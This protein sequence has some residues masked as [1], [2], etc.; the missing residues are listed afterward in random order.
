MKKIILIIFALIFALAAVGCSGTGVTFSGAYWNADPMNRGVADIYEEC[1]YTV[2]AVTE[3]EF[4]QASDLTARFEVGEGSYYLT[5]LKTENGKYVYET[6]LLLNG[7]YISADGSE[8]EVD[9]DYINTKTVFSGIDDN[10]KPVKSERSLKTLTF[11]GDEMKTLGYDA[12]V[13]YGDEAKVTVTPHEGSEDYFAL[14]SEGYTLGDYSSNTFLDDNTVIFAFRAMNFEKTFSYSVNVLDI[15]SKAVK[16]VICTNINYTDQEVVV[17]PIS[18]TGYTENGKFSNFKK[19]DAKGV[20]F[21][22]G[23]TYSQYFRYVYYA[24]SSYAQDGSENNEARHRP[25]KIYQPAI[26]KTGYY[27]CY[28]LET[29]TTVAP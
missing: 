6:R 3:T 13:V 21:K 28:T 24:V 27:F 11:V 19:I 2:T 9:G 7:K 15:L 29:V 14:V 5:L 10:F 4:A 25:I 22:T 1:R 17:T 23:G 8:H 18:L 20:A 16:E 12:E 26:Y